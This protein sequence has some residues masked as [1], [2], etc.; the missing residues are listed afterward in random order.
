[1]VPTH[2]VRVIPVVTVA[3]VCIVF[4]ARIARQVNF[5]S[6]TRSADRWPPAAVIRLLGI[7]ASGSGRIGIVARW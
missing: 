5:D 6:K 3:R 4:I 7:T 1:M 2:L